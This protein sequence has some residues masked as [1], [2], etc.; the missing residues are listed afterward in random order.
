MQHKEIDCHKA[1]ITSYSSHLNKHNTV[2]CSNKQGAPEWEGKGSKEK[3]RGVRRK[4][5]AALMLTKVSFVIV[6]LTEFNALEKIINEHHLF[7]RS[8]LC[9]VTSVRTTKYHSP[10]KINQ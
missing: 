8:S 6:S 9:L 10:T 2:I 7:R 3:C 5:L 1:I 4:N